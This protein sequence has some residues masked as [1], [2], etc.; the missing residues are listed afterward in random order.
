MTP[1]PPRT[2]KAAIAALVLGLLSCFCVPAL[3]AVIFGLIGLRATSRDP[4]LKGRG[5]A[6]SGLAMGVV[7]GLLGS[8]AL[9]ALPDFLVDRQRSKQSSCKGALKQLATAQRDLMDQSKRYGGAELRKDLAPN[10][11]YRFLLGPPDFDALTPA[12]RSALPSWLTDRVGVTGA[13]PD[14][15]YLLACVGNLDDDPA[16]DV[17]AVSSAPLKGLSDF[18]DAGEQRIIQLADDRDDLPI[19]R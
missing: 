7:F 13:C 8:S 17:W 2:S 4:T 9:I 3:P 11:T 18:A 1:S 19:E 12:E 15:S 10:K 14:C 5:M 16:L 6:N